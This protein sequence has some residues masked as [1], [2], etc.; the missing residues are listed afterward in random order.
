M[1]DLCAGLS[2]LLSGVVG[3]QT[4]DTYAGNGS[5][6]TMGDGGPAIQAGFP[7]ILAFQCHGNDL[8]ISQ[9][10]FSYPA[11][12]KIDSAGIIRAIAGNLN[13]GFSGDGGPAIQAELR[14]PLESAIDKNGNFYFSDSQNQR[15]RKI[16]TSGII[17]TIA[18]RGTAGY[19]GDNGPAINAEL[20][21]PTGLVIDSHGNLFIGDVENRIMRKIDTLGTITTVA[22]TPGSMGFSG[23]G[24]PAINALLAGPGR[25]AIDRNDNIYFTDG[26]NYRIRKISTAGIITTIAGTGINNHSGDGGLATA[27]DLFAPGGMDIDTLGNVYIAEYSGSRIRKVDQ[28]GIITTIAGI[29]GAGSSG[30]GGPAISAEI[31]GPTDVAVGKNGNLYVL[32]YNMNK[33]RVI[34]GIYNMV[35]I[36]ELELKPEVSLFPNPNNGTF[37]V[38]LSNSSQSS[39]LIILNLLGQKIHEEKMTRLQNTIQLSGL[40]PGI[41]GY[42]IRQDNKQISAGKICIERN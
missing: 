41:Y 13:V 19:S 7:A 6:G 27:A 32:E 3:A 42:M 23:D 11:I 28:A 26:S 8:Y 30:D 9:G 24:G 37:H 33:I 5:S 15:I 38:N 21:Y 22:G 34:N 2:L 20:N 4:I 10:M 12:R 17:T 14:Y 35:G 39:E 29:G 1:K 16:N 36:R 40:A 31:S 18:G 25:M